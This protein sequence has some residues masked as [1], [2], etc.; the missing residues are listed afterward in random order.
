MRSLLVG[1]SL[2]AVVVSVLAKPHQAGQSQVK[3]GDINDVKFY[4]Y[5]RKNGNNGQEFP[6]DL[7]TLDSTDFDA[8]RPRT[9]VV[10]HGFVNDI[11]FTEQ[12]VDEAAENA[13]DVGTRVGELVSK[14]IDKTGLP[15]AKIHAIGHS[16]GAQA[17]GHLGRKVKADTGSKVARMSGL[18][19][20]RPYFE[21]LDPA[22]QLNKNDGEYVDVIHTNSGSLINGCLSFM[23]P[24]GHA[25]FYPAGGDHQ[26][27]KPHQAGQSQVKKGDINDVKFYLYT[28]KN[29][30]NGQEFPFDLS[31]LDSTDFDA[32]RP[33]TFVVVH[34]FVNDSKRNCNIIGVD[35]GLLASWTN[36]FEAAEN[37]LDVVLVSVSWLVRSLTKTGLPH[38]KIHAI[39]HSLG[40]QA[41]GHL[42]RKVKADTGSKV[43]RLM[44]VLHEA[45]GPCDFY[46][47]GAITSPWL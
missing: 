46:P 9:F 1:F 25:D 47:A 23:K 2:L 3:K 20:A 19:P 31:T 37:A 17:L 38:A 8:S 15:H 21:I 40:A 13:L 27:A 41:L 34:G 45:Y 30:N 22:L 28:R 29:G 42:G 16:L 12:F 4:L 7:S 43:A 18:D 32:S 33:R 14:I 5:T 11:E 6:F 39:G 35:W 24:M 10:V 36:Y 26:P 44:L